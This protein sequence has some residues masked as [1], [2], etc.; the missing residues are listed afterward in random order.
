MRALTRSR[1]APQR[2]RAW[3]VDISP[4]GDLVWTRDGGLIEVITHLA[5]LPHPDDPLAPQLIIGRT[6]TLWTP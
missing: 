4:D 6:P 3:V 2:A 1:A 5:A